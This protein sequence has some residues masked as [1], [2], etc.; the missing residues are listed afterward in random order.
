MRRLVW[1]TSFRRT[2]KKIKRLDP[3]KANRVLRVA[4]DLATDP[5]QQHLRTHKLRGTLAGLWAAWVEYDCRIV[6]FFEPDS[7]GGD[8]MIALVD[9]G[10][11][12]EVY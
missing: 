5:F 9:V 12:E 3:E 10:N 8:E 4:E 7:A 2:F 11:H 6:F 1:H